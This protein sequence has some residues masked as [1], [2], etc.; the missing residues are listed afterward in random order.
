MKFLFIAPR[1]HT[2]LYYQAISLIE[3]GNQ[4]KV[5]VLYKGVSEYYDGIDIQ[6]TGLSLPSKMLLKVVS[7]F[8]KTYLKSNLELRIQSPARALKKQLIDYKPD[9]II[10]KAYQDLLAIKVL[11]VAKRLNIRV[12]MMTQT[13]FAHIKGAAW[14]FKLN[15]KLFRIMGVKA[16]ITPILSNFEAFKKAGIENVHYLPFVYPV[17]TLAI[18]PGFDEGFNI[19]SVGKFVKRKDLMLLVKAVEI[20]KQKYRL[21]L[22]IIGEKSDI[23]YFNEIQN[24]INE[25]SLSPFATISTNLS[26]PEICGLYPQYH[27]FVLPAYA[28]PAAYSPVEAMANGLPVICSHQNGTSC[29]IENGKNGFIFEAKN[30]ENLTLQIE[31]LVSDRQLWQNMSENAYKMAAENHNPLDFSNKLMHLAKLK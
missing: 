26:Y 18:K 22:H 30:L 25:N 15:M 2:N 19:I 14:L 28:E 24:Y 29:Y 1:F 21:R 31:K 8:R 10:L 17:N 20:L 4:V 27:L 16:Y 11:I 13:P 7:F 5:L 3:A 9:V 12:F 6:E 23:Q